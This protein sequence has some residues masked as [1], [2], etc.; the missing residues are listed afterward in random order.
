MAAAANSDDPDTTIAQAIS[1]VLLSPD[2]MQASARRSTFVHV[3]ASDAGAALAFVPVHV[4]IAAGAATFSGASTALD[5]VTDAAGEFDLDLAP[6]TVAGNVLLHFRFSASSDGSSGEQTRDIALHIVAGVEK[7]LVIGL[8]TAGFG[9]V[10][11]AIES[12]DNAANGTLSRRGALSIYGSGAIAKNT[13]GTFAYRSADSL[14]HGT[15]TGPFVDNP[16]DRPFPTYGDASVRSVDALSRNRI[17]ARVDNGASSAS[18]GEFYAQAAPPQA[19]GGYNILVNGARVQLQGSRVGVG[20]FSARNDVAFDRVVLSPTGLGIADRILQPDIVT[21]SDIVTLLSLDRRTG[22]VTQ[23]R[24]LG[25]GTDYVLDYQSGLLRFVNILLPYDDALNPQIVQVQ[26]QYGVVGGTASML[27]A[28]ASFSLGSAQ[29]TAPHFDS[30]YLNDATGAGNLTLFGQS[31]SGSA[32]T[33]QW[34]ASHEHS[35]G[36]GPVSTVHYGD[37]GDRY[38]ASIAT[39]DRPFTFDVQFDATG[40]GYA[41]PF[42]SFAT[43]GLFSL[44]ATVRQRLS[45]VTNLEL[46]YSTAK[47]TLPAT[48]GVPA[49]ANADTQARIGVRVTPSTRLTYHAAIVAESATGNGVSIPASAFLDGAAPPVAADPFAFP[50]DTSTVVYTPGSG[51]A[52]MLDAGVAWMFAPRATLSVNQRTALSASTDP[53]DPPRTDVALELPT[54]P[55]GKAFVRQRWQRAQSATFAPSDQ[56]IGSAGTATSSTTAGF[57]QQIGLTTVQTGYAVE[58]TANGTDFYQAV[59]ARRTIALGQH[60]T[61]DAFVQAG[62]AIA[63]TAGS[64]NFFVFGTTLSFG[65]QTFRA[66]GDVQVR[67]GFNAGSTYVLGAAGPISLAVSLFGSL[68]SAY[69]QAVHTSTARGGLAYRPVNDD[70]AVTLLS[71]DSQTGNLTNYDSYVTNVAQL[72]QIYRPSRRMELGAS[73]AYKITGDQTFAPRTIIYGVRANQ[74]IGARFDLGAELHRSGTAPID[75]SQATGLAIEAGVRV[76]DR[77]RVAGGYNFSGFADPAVAVSPT[78]RGVYVTLSSYIDRIFGWGKDDVRK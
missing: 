10:P 57:E 26:Y 35:A 51:S 16:D 29:A 25:R 6:G 65:L 64:P 39:H 12:A 60:L 8:A 42:G 45:R 40:A 34:S 52:L 67:T 20:A 59:G 48:V 55:A 69:T 53:Y 18:W 66:S 14:D 75:G 5:I 77:L 2:T 43:P 73:L 72:Q 28:K 41:N 49:I 62:R 70:R 74:R 37:A 71:I 38:R 13:H 11:G 23:Q 68:T 36:L 58:R 22:A 3:R 63:L 47:N 46:A 4:E 54:G 50:I 24:V 9:A 19:A 21:G 15:A 44:G 7:P 33:L 78:H 17:F 30:W 32:A 27:G 56:Y 61:G 31:V 1:L 76:G